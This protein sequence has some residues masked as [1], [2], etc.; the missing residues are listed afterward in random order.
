MCRLFNASLLASHVCYC[1]SALIQCA[2]RRLCARCAVE[3]SESSR[4]AATCDSIWRSNQASWRTCTIHN[5]P[6]CQWWRQHWDPA[7]SSYIWYS[8]YEHALPD[9]PKL[10]CLPDS[11][12]SMLLSH[13]SWSL[14]LSVL[15]F[16]AVSSRS[17]A[18]RCRPGTVTAITSPTSAICRHTPSTCSY[19]SDGRHHTGSCLIRLTF[20]G[21]QCDV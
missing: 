11:W 20:T 3:A 10:D 7:I 6:G 16:R 4:C 19:Q 18:V 9:L 13:L 5:E 12:C 8:P 17:L 21:L 14:L 15:C 2:L 1:R